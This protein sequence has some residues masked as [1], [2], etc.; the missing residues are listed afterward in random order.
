VSVKKKQAQKPTSTKTRIKTTLLLIFFYNSIML[1]NQ[2]PQKQGL[3]QLI[4]YSFK[5]KTP[6]K[7]QLPQK[8]GLR[9]NSV[10]RIFQ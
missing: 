4:N 9:P 5:K 3:R 7:N 1:K 6:L 8:Q 10:L 2:L